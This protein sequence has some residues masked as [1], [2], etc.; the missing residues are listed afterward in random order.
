MMFEWSAGHRALSA[1]FLTLVVL[2]LP[3]STQARVRT[4]PVPT[5]APAVLT[6]PDGSR[7]IAFVAGERLC[8]TVQASGRDRPLDV[9]ASGVT[10]SGG[11]DEPDGGCMPLPVLAPL[12]G[13]EFADISFGNASGD[14]LVTGTAVAAV[15]LKRGG[16]VLTHAETVASPLPGAAAELRFAFLPAPKSRA[17][18]AAVDE[19][20]LLDAT[21]AVRRAQRPDFSDVEPVGQTLRRGGA[22]G[23]AWRLSSYRQQVLSPTPLLPE[24]KVTVT[25]LSVHVGGGIDGVCDDER[26][27]GLSYLPVISQSC[28]PLGISVAILVRS[29][30]RRVA[31]VLG[32]GN[33]RDV[34]LRDV[35]GD[36]DGLAAGITL[37]GRQIAIRR[38]VITGAGGDVLSSEELQLAPTSAPDCNGV[39]S[40]SYSYGYS[41]AGLRTPGPHAFQA[42]DRGV[43]LCL[44]ADRAPNVRYDCSVPPIEAETSQLRIIPRKDAT[45]VAG[46]V[47]ADVATMRLTL[48]DGT[49]RDVPAAPIPGYLGQYVSTTLL[50]NAEI[51]APRHVGGYQLLDA[52]SRVLVDHDAGGLPDLRHSATVLRTPGLPPLRAGLVTGTGDTAL[53]CL[54]FGRLA[55]VTDCAAGGANSYSVRALCKPRRIVILGLLSH[56]ADNLV[57]QTTGGREI[58]AR[59]AVLPAAIRRGKG[60]TAALLVLPA[61]V[62]ARGLLLRGK[63]AGK[64]DLALPPA[65]E[66]CGYQTYARI[67]GGSLR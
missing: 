34:P 14:F 4:V 56:A 23:H 66:Q 49:R 33:R 41:D 67:T 58:T 28:S 50:V 53:P 65:T 48:D 10:T 24:R 15:E 22:G 45:T 46:L 21:G 20:A 55:E 27:A 25:C 59:K 30:V 39:L 5:D 61:R 51:P 11:S 6:A 36:P 38:L 44:A 64:A 37:V 8:F 40:Q 26:L 7:L 17:D 60:T 13:E 35:P 3:V 62:G 1:V 9:L 63:A 18:A 43:Q 57:V 32:D 47:P 29:Q 52:R 54:G 12:A 31:L 16:R 42:A 2:A 19:I